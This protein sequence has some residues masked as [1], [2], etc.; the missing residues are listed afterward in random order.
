MSDPRVRVGFVGAG[1]ISHTHVRAAREIPGVEVTGFWAR[2]PERTARMAQE[3][4]GTAHATLDA[5]LDAAPEVVVVGTPSG[6]HADHAVAAARRGI[7]VLVEKPLDVS[8]ARVDAL[9]EEADRAGA[10]VGV[11][12]QDRTAPALA[13]LKRAIDAG[14]LGRVFLTSAR[15]RWYRPPEYYGGSRWRGTWALDGGGA[16]MNQGVHTVD[17]LLWLLGDVARVSAA[18]RTAMHK[19]EVED[20]AVACI[21]L[22]SGGVATLEATTA[23]Y[24]GFPR[25][26]E[27]SGTE[28]T[29]VVESDRIVS[30]DLKNP[31]PE[32]PPQDAGNTNAAASSPI[33]SD[34]RGHRRVLED[35]LRA[36]REGGTPL[37]D[38]RDGRRSVELVEAIYTSARTGA[39]V[40]LGAGVGAGAPD[41][42]GAV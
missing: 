37:C 17:L 8:T 23:A 15:V 1:N 13:W 11:I 35:F 22:V 26:L 20:T 31:P 32:P 9:L 33:V 19:I 38:G 36:V 30:A 25:R 34:V 12:F 3:Y 14:A 40:T 5:F 7:H 27:I 21:E 4:G 29:V 18:A 6:L 10:R 2:D 41:W 28:G 42:P 16:L 39:P 24:P